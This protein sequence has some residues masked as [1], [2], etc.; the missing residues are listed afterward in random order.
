MNDELFVGLV[1]QLN[2]SRINQETLAARKKELETAFANN[3]EYVR[4]CGMLKTMSDQVNNIQKTLK[5]QLVDAPEYTPPFKAAWLVN[6]EKVS[7]D[8]EKALEWARVNMKAAV[9]E[10][11][12][13]KMLTDF[14]KSNPTSAPY[15]TITE[16]KD[17]RIASDLSKFI[18]DASVDL[19]VPF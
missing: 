9:S 17:A 4:V 14:A 5:S 7:I 10:V 3:P 19:D 1:K 18:G 6:S 16:Y 15:A 8:E 13:K 2:T 12:D 11:V